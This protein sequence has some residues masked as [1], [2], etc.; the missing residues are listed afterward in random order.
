M[1]TLVSDFEA[2]GAIQS[3]LVSINLKEALLLFR[4]IITG[5]TCM[6]FIWIP[7]DTHLNSDGGIDPVLLDVV[8]FIQNRKHD[9]LKTY[10]NNE[11]VDRA[12]R[13]W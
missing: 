5:V 12:L 4:N 11:V 7:S 2:V 9:G 1:I 10:A 8:N 3:A 13:L 6:K